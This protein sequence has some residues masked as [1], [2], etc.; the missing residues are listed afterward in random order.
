MLACPQCRGS[1]VATSHDLRCESCVKTYPIVD[2]IPLLLLD[3]K[4]AEH[5]ELDHHNGHHTHNERERQKDFFDN[6]VEP[7]FEITR[8]RGTPAL[9]SWYYAEKFRKSIA[10]LESLLDGSTVLT[11][12]GGS[13]MDAEFLASRGARVI[14]S[15]LSLGAAKRA[16]ERARRFGLAIEPIVADVERLPFADRA[17]DVAYVHDGLHHIEN[18]FAG[19]KEMTR[20][21]RSAISVTEP[22][23]AIATKIAIYLGLALEREEAGNRVARMRRHEIAQFLE[24]AGFKVVSA[25]RYVMYYQHNPGRL[26]EFLSKPGLL[27]V[28]QGAVILSNLLIGRWG[29]RLGVTATRVTGT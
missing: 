29:N 19:L 23:D 14:A 3:L 25:Q 18:P 13:G 26:I 27:G 5:D 16:S 15:D 8:P 21:A 11:V 4:A 20:V 9:Y 28:S 2:G 12:C 7:E 6:E 17:V 10:N 24:Q 1:L 22:A